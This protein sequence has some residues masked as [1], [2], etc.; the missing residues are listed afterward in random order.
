MGINSKV[1]DTLGHDANLKSSIFS[2]QAPVKR[3]RRQLSHSKV[4]LSGGSPFYASIR[5]PSPR[6]HE[7][8]LE[9][10]IAEKDIKLMW[11]FYMDMEKT[12]LSNRD[13]NKTYPTVEL[14]TKKTKKKSVGRVLHDTLVA[15]LQAAM[16]S[17]DDDEIK[18]AVT[19]ADGKLQI[20]GIGGVQLL[21]DAKRHLGM[22]EDSLPD[23]RMIAT[24]GEGIKPRTC[25]T[26]APPIV[27][28]DKK[29]RA[30]VTL[31]RFSNADLADMGIGLD[32]LGEEADLTAQ[33]VG[34][35]GLG[36]DADLADQGVG[37]DGLGEEAELAD[38]GVGI[39][40]L[41]E[42]PADEAAAEEEEVA[43]E[44]A[45]EAPAEDGVDFGGDAF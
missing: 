41:G 5:P 4:G 10:A 14:G 36:E 29:K 11:R 24:S 26:R 8:K 30:S 16:D 19:D 43:E 9:K 20:L 42:E 23:L 33:G 2:E 45:E 32:G 38:E 25:H 15:N 12:P 31:P 37:L 44:V 34:F 40:G 35:E 22:D 21:K 39:E 6:R 3:C 13:L 17:G 7:N 1:V 18:R 28:F 27:V